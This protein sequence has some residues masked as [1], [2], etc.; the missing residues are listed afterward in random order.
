VYI[1]PAAKDHEIK[2][3]KLYKILLFDGNWRESIYFQEETLQAR[4]ISVIPA[5]KF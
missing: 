4:N 2:M 1:C 3:K 5:I